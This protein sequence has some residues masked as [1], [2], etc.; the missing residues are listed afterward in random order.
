MASVAGNPIADG[1][2]VG[3]LYADVVEAVAGG[4]VGWRTC[5]VFHPH[6]WR[7]IRFDAVTTDQWGGL[8][9]TIL[10]ASLSVVG[11][12]PLAVL[13]ALGRVSDAASDQDAV[14]G[15]CGIDSGCAADFG[16]VHGVVPVPAVYAGRFFD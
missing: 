4:R 12:F 1:F 3:K 8:P 13:L 14:Y 16:V 9:L 15:L 2:V 11:A 10:L 5:G 7:R 6:A